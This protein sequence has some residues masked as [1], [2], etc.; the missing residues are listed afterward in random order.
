MLYSAQLTQLV[1]VVAP[2]GEVKGQ[3]GEEDAA[4][5]FFGFNCVQFDDSVQGSSPDNRIKD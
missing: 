1:G 5:D 4:G 3:E 2:D